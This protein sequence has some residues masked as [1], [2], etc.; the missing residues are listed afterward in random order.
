MRAAGRSTVVCRT[1]PEPP[2]SGQSRCA[3]AQA[4]TARTPLREKQ[5]P[6]PPAGANRAPEPEVQ[7][8]CFSRRPHWCDACVARVTMGETHASNGWPWV[9]R[10]R[11][12]GG[13]GWP[14]RAWA[15]QG[16]RSPMAT[17]G[18]G[19]AG[20]AQPNS[21]PGLGRSGDCAAQWVHGGPENT[22]PIP[23][24]RQ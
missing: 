19:G 11:R 17:Q 12:T 18:L 3:H 5:I 16:L 2:D 8:G 14:P 10:M 13:H 6:P 21:H 7:G 15:E 23:A 22:L 1:N 4:R 24:P 20:T 9:R